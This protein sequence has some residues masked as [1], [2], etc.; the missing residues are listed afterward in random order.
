MDKLNILKKIEESGLDKN[1][2]IVISGASLV[3][4]GII[5]E[6]DDIDL[7]C[8]LEYYNSLNWKT[9]IGAFGIEIKY[10]DV[11][12]IS[13]NLYDLNQT[14]IINNIKFMNVQKCLEL[15]QK[16]GRTK[17]KEFIKYIKK[18]NKNFKNFF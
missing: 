5:E 4:Q 17:D 16:L 8:D 9:K 7:S 2:I 14:I 10:F 3:V 12:E 13:Y 18:F 11:F 1:R 6:T 15:K